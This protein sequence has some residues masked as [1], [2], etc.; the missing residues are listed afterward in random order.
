[1]SWPKSRILFRRVLT[2]F[3][4]KRLFTTSFSDA[5]NIIGKKDFSI[6]CSKLFF[7]KPFIM[8]QNFALNFVYVKKI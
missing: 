1:M 8:L 7:F 2:R 5:L 4:T 6:K 3:G